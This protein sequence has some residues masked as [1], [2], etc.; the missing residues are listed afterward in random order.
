MTGFK[1]PPH[2][3]RK[4]AACSCC[5]SVG[6][7]PIE[8]KN[9]LDK[10]EEFR[11]ECDNKEVIT[12]CIYR[13]EKHNYEVGGVYNS[14]HRLGMACDLHVEGLTVDEMVKAA[15]RAGFGGIGRYNGWIHVDTGPWGRWNG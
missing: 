9:L 2:F 8:L 15:E 6:S 1:Y 13:C 10:L 7:N 11:T 12:H 4:E 5:G 3:T 14:L